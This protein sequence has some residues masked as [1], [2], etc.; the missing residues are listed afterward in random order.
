MYYIFFLAY[1]EVVGVYYSINFVVQ[2]DYHE[3]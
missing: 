3:Y 1:S 2:Y